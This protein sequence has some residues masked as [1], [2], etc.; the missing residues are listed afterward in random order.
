MKKFIII[1]AYF[2]L[3][4]CCY[5]FLTAAAAAV[6]PPQPTPDA[7]SV[8]R[9]HTEPSSADYDACTAQAA[10]ERPS[11]H[12]A[13]TAHAAWEAE[14]IASKRESDAEHLLRYFRRRLHATSSAEKKRWLI[15]IRRWTSYRH[16]DINLRDES[17]RVALHYAVLAGP[18]YVAAILAHHG[19]EFDVDIDPNI[20]DRKRE[21]PLFY[22]V[23]RAL[24]MG[25][26]KNL[27][28][29][30]LLLGHRGPGMR[31]PINPN[32]RYGAKKQTLLHLLLQQFFNPDTESKPS[33]MTVYHLLREAGASE[34]IPDR[35]GKTV[36]DMIADA[37]ARAAEAEDEDD[38]DDVATPTP[39]PPHATTGVK[40]L[41]GMRRSPASSEETLNTQPS[42]ATLGAPS[43]ASA[44]KEGTGVE[45]VL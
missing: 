15:T 32:L 34:D 6:Y 17:Q 11:E 29:L 30:Q 4:S 38:D 14:M 21:T 23:A 41:R 5:P 22:A 16:I 45:E 1:S 7:T 44:S 13:V 10:E 28:T 26:P 19:A 12:A 9:R 37:A 3:L 36:K 2:F 24:S 20:R 42:T 40:S 31:H 18:S 35:N 25:T 8:D 43:T 39:A 33:F 27:K